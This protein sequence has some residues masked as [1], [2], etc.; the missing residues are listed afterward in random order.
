VAGADSTDAALLGGNAEAFAAFYRRHEDAVLGFFLRRTGQPEVAADLTAESF[1]RAL[2]GRASF[3]SSIGEPRAWLFGIA[4]HLL[5]RSLEA[6]RVE[7]ETRLRLAMEPLVLDDEDLAR[8]NELTDAP[9]M[10]ALESL[11]LEQLAAVKGRVL[12]EADYAEIAS[13]LRCSESVVRQRVSRGL[14]TLR[15]S[16]EGNS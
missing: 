1:A 2:E 4:K 3:D 8:I 14:R 10:T 11:P 9:A 6:G 16:L 15:R 7:N 12:A 5:A 13:E